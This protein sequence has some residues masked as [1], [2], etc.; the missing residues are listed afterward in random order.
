MKNV[1]YKQLKIQTYFTETKFT[2]QMKQQIFS[3]RVRMA[4]FGENFRGQRDQVLCP[5]KCPDRDS[6]QH[7]YVCEKITSK[8]TITG[9]YNEIFNDSISLHVGK[10]IY[11]ILH[12]RKSLLEEKFVL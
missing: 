1:S 9:D 12:T 3:Y 10:T 11:N 5:F 8:T 6:Q 2:T 4:D 7:S